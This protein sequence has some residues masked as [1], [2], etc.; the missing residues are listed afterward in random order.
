[1]I[2]DRS[3]IPWRAAEA[4]HWYLGEQEISRRATVTPCKTRYAEK[5]RDLNLDNCQKGGDM[6]IYWESGAKQRN[7]GVTLPSV[8]ALF[9]DILER[10]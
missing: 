1:M 10:K 3:G 2:G 8:K 5:S 4:M 9:P 7:R 6:S